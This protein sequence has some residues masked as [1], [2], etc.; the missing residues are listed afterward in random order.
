MFLLLILPILISG[1]IVFTSHPYHFYRLHRYE[2]QLLYLGSAKIGL[3][4][5]ICSIFAVML[6][7]QYMP[8][9][10]KVIGFSINI[11]VHSYLKELLAGFDK[12]RS[13]DLAWVLIITCSSLLSAHIY[14][15]LAKL[16][17]Y[18]RCINLPTFSQLTRYIRFRYRWACNF[19][20]YKKAKKIRRAPRLSVSERSKVL[21]MASILNDSPLDD[22]FLKSY[23]QDGFY[24][25]MTME[26]RKVYIG[27]VTSLGEPNESEGLDQEI[28]ITPFASGYRNDDNLKV[29]LTTK[30][31]E[32][33]SDISITIRQDKIISATRFTEEV[34]RNFQEYEQ[35]GKT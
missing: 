34:F 21:L 28:T 25:M 17:L 6:L 7:N 19:L 4:C 22:L 32:V 5:T 33:D 27:R 15:V 1:Y 24:L 30:Y 14:T 29:T 3:F 20:K 35:Q 11:D 13:A 23:I 16:K 18:L 9:E 8:A 12:S 2:G 31:D 26:D 10:V